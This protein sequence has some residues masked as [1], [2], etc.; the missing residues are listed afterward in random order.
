VTINDNAVSGNDQLVVGSAA[1]GTL[2]FGSINLGNNGYVTAT[3]TFGT[4]SFPT[5][6][7]WQPSTFTLTISLGQQTSGTTG[8]VNGNSTATYTPSASLRDRAGNAI[9]GTASTANTRLF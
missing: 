5:G 3:S 9:T 2:N 8:D 4:P 7:V 6:V 1:C